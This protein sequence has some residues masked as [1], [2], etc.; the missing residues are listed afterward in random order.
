MQ[1]HVGLTT[2]TGSIERYAERFDLLELRIDPEKLPPNPT[3]RKMRARA[4]KLVTSFFLPGRALSALLP[5]PDAIQPILAAADVLGASW[6]VLQTGTDLGPS[7][8]TKDRLAALSERL[9]GSSRKVAWEPH[10]IWDDQGSEEYAAALGISLVQDLSVTRGAG[11][12]VIYTRLR[13]LGPGAQLRSS[14]LEHLAI[15]IG[16]AEQAFVVIEGRPSQRARSRIERV[17][18]GTNAALQDG[19]ED[20]DDDDSDGDGGDADESDDAG[21]DEN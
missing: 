21:E 14:A 6:F 10:G 12:D 3:L 1:L 19:D 15:E 20:E 5:A 8:R 9:L 4:P 11:P 17:V 18:I 2:V 16:D 13:S 7:Q